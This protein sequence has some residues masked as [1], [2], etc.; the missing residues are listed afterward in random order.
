MFK[1]LNL[2][3][4]IFLSMFIMLLGISI[5]SVSSY[6]GFK[7]IGNE[8]V[9]IAEY[10][11]PINS[12]LT[13]L[14]KDILEEEIL[15]YK[16]IITCVDVRSQ[17]FKNIEKHILKLEEETREIISKTK[18]VIQ[19]AIIH[20]KDEKT[21]KLYNH[22]LEE[23]LILEKEQLAY[24]KVLIQFD[25]DVK[26]PNYDNLDND[27][28]KLESKITVLEA[29][30]LDLMK[31][32]GKLLI[33]STK[34][35][36]KDEQE[37]LRIIE[38]ISIIVLIFSIFISLKLTKF[39]RK[40]I[41]NF[42]NGLINFFEYLNKNTTDVKLLDTSFNDEIGTMAKT[43]NEN[44]IRTKKLLE[45]DQ[46]VINKTV[47]VLNEFEQGDL[48]KRVEVRTSNESL[49][50]LT[51]LLNQMASNIENNIDNILK[52]LNEYSN[53]NF[54]NTT[55]TDN[56]K[57]HFLRLALGINTLGESITKNLN[58]NKQNGLTLEKNSILL[59]EN[60][61]T[62]S[63]STANAST[64]LEETAAALEEITRTMASN[65]ANIEDMTRYTTQVSN[66]ANKGEKLV[67]NTMKAM[68]EI[69]E[70]T[71]AIAEAIT[72]IDQIAF[73]TNI[74]SLNAAVEAAT[75]GEYGKGFAVVAQEV[76]NLA[77]RSAEA[78]K[79]IKILVE[80]A[81]T[82]ANNGKNISNSM[83]EEYKDLNKGI[84][85]TLELIKN[86]DEASRE[87]QGG[88]MQINDAVSQLDQQTQK[89]SSIA[90]EA[91]NI[92]KITQDISRTIITDL[93]SKKFKD[94]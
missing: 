75:A 20:N 1:N 23:L 6:L 56:I 39:I 94:K 8:I 48:S 80:T 49:M 92:S 11:I 3:T 28:K 16:F 9:E 37:V 52:I 35:A 93:N 53:N 15:T 58:E 87:Q 33:N 45:E 41:F 4:K 65:T 29:H 32:M 46:E 14:E 19:E 78:A 71:Q 84:S 24:K 30:V 64:S 77:T 7:K 74:L 12:L 59:E 13:E 42:K 10:Q 88:V 79:E 81:T 62:L 61:S 27:R 36:E 55:N 63:N 90:N 86:I 5:I 83:L 44:I 47:L 57:E 31:K 25:K 21:K 2:T 73:Q 26:K 50:K 40:S 68:D 17:E 22:F 82:K 51:N 18:E 89:N 60:I 91:S 70:Q 67:T 85:K 76:R 69:N 54:L 43:I 38:I 34:Q 72:I 66:S